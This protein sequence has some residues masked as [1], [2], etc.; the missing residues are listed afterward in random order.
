MPRPI[1]EGNLRLSLVSCPVALY[2]AIARARDVSFNLLHK[3]TNN[4][5]RMVPHDPEIGEVKRSELSALTPITSTTVAPAQAG[6]HTC[7][8]APDESVDSRLRGNDTKKSPHPAHFVRHPRSASRLD[9]ANAGEGFFCSLSR[10]GGLEP[11]SGS[12]VGVRALTP[13]PPS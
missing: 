12:R 7:F 2:N 6:A 4:R 1:W 9:P 8:L 13:S 10:S 5:I 3:K 11:R